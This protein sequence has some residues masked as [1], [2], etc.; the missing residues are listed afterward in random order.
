MNKSD[1]DEFTLDWDQIF[2]E[3][4]VAPEDTRDIRLETSSGTWSTTTFDADRTLN[5]TPISSNTR[6]S[7]AFEL[8]LPSSTILASP[9]QPYAVLSSLLVPAQAY[10][11]LNGNYAGWSSFLTTSD[12]SFNPFPMDPKL[13]GEAELVSQDPQSD[14]IKFLFT[15][16][17]DIEAS[18][19]KRFNHI[20]LRHD[21]LPEA[22]SQDDEHDE[23][24]SIA[25]QIGPN[26]NS[27]DIDILRPR[28]Q[29]YLSSHVDYSV[30]MMYPQVTQRSY[31]REKRFMCPQPILMLF[32]EGW[33][34]KR[35]HRRSNA[36][37]FEVEKCALGQVESTTDKFP[38]STEQYN[39][40]ATSV[41]KLHRRKSNP[42]TR[43]IFKGLF[44]NDV[45]SFKLN[46][47]GTDSDSGE[48]KFQIHSG[49]IGVISKPSRSGTS[50]KDSA[51]TIYSGETIALFNR[52]KAQTVSTRFLATSEDGKQLI[53]RHC[54]WQ[55]FR[56]WLRDD[57]KCPK[58]DAHIM[59]C[60]WETPTSAA[61]A[62]AGHP[63]IY[64]DVVVLENV[65]TGLTT[66]PLYVRRTMGRDAVVSDP[67]GTD[68]QQS[69]PTKDTISQLQK[70]AFELEAGAGCFLSLKNESVVVLDAKPKS[71][72]AAHS[73]FIQ[74][75]YNGCYQ[76]LPLFG[77]YDSFQYDLMD[78]G[79]YDFLS[80]FA[81]PSKELLYRPAPKNK[82]KISKQK[83]QS[84]QTLIEVSDLSI[85][86]IVSTEVRGFTFEPVDTQ[87]SVLLGD[88]PLVKSVTRERN[89]IF[90]FQ[91]E[92]LHQQL[93]VFAGSIPAKVTCQFSPTSLV[94]E[95]LQE[96]SIHEKSHV[97]NATSD[98]N[99]LEH[100]SDFHPILLVC[101][102]L[103]VYRT[104]FSAHIRN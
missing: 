20:P 60:E 34:Q 14:N 75:G 61:N 50:S 48:L 39:A 17:L 53:T 33:N 97:S 31:G 89:S 47:C 78:M 84:H 76:S 5:D 83:M 28:I 102:N 98:I 2:P 44:V 80:T 58:V 73:E 90:L 24:Q 82:K 3:L 36:M 85:W 104:S 67:D 15:S 101:A 22:V 77:T 79:N 19:P 27:F 18:N 6:C 81:Q 21:E 99:N 12:F 8:D 30:I 1:L 62:K 96:V 68:K 69:E 100:S 38:G 71:R 23:Q 92:N 37:S 43:S 10:N 40:N 9:I 86:S 66:L 93:W 11:A 94:V 88:A 59:P 103:V 91:G 42:I 52:V 72:S 87:T 49:S 35:S 64:D 26:V 45:K 46:F 4:L 95:F 70:V 16:T 7:P 13:T 29:Q 25:K 57:P 63:L 55:P 65:T 56:I 41:S 74:D 51:A 32:G 54:P